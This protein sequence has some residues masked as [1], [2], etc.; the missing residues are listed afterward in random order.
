M[1][2][3]SN[4]KIKST[5]FQRSNHFT[6]FSI[7]KKGKVFSFHPLMK[8]SLKHLCTRSSIVRCQIDISKCVAVIAA[9]FL[10]QRETY[11]MYEVQRERKIVGGR[12]QNHFRCYLQYFF[13]VIHFQLCWNQKRAGLYHCGTFSRSYVDMNWF[14]AIF[15][16]ISTIKLNLVLWH[17]S[18]NGRMGGYVCVFV[19]AENPLRFYRISQTWLSSH[20]TV[21]LALSHF[22][23]IA[24]ICVWH[25]VEKQTLIYPTGT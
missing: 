24:Y 6:F 19:C 4:V 9:F 7:V 11:V 16:Y 1:T 21:F 25:Q 18:R 12:V 2:N 17:G 5:V 20:I 3:L 22:L 14:Y 15:V 8:K 23:T 13:V 10:A